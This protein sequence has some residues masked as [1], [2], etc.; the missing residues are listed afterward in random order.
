MSLCSSNGLNSFSLRYVKTQSRG[1]LKLKDLGYS[2]LA[3]D[4]KPTFTARVNHLEEQGQIAGRVRRRDVTD[5]QLRSRRCY[6]GNQ[7]V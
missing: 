5:L 2:L 4:V 1:S 3:T 7:L 6:V